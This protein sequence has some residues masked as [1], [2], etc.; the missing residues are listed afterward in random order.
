MSSL[1]RLDQQQKRYLTACKQTL[2]YFSFCYFSFGIETINTF[3]HSRGSL[4]NH[5][6][7]QTPYL[8]SD[9]NGAKTIPFGVAYSYMA[10]IKQLFDAGEVNIDYV[11]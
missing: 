3:I 2:F 6:R 7:F 1:L 9:Q 11:I 10:Y 5:T 4:E 8:F